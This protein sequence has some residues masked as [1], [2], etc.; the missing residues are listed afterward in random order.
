[1]SFDWA[2]LL[3]V[4][5]VLSLADLGVS[6]EACLRSAV[7]RAYYAAFGSARHRARDRRLQTRQSA[8]E[9]GEV[10]VLFAQ[11]YGEAGME[12]AKLLSRLR[13]N[14]N[15]AD[16]EDHCEDQEKLT[17]ESLVYARRVLTLLA[18]L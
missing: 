18:T 11:Q 8:A 14:R 1:M 12:I 5:E 16:Y 3:A 6:R 9:H 4:A 2:E 13:T 7:G 15:I 17:A 10:S